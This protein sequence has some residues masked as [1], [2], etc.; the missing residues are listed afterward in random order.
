MVNKIIGWGLFG[1]GAAAV[2]LSYPIVRTTLK[3]NIPANITDTYIMLAGVLVLIIG[4]L[5]AFKGSA[6]KQPAE[7]PIYHGKNIVGYR[8]MK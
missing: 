3:I 6:G 7:V 4:A 8:R 2:A 1:I 5:F